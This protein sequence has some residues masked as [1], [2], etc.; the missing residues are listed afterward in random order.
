MD[1]HDNIINLGAADHL[2]EA[3]P[4]GLICTVCNLGITL[5]ASKETG[6]DISSMFAVGI[7]KHYNTKK[8][9]IA[10]RKKFN[11]ITRLN[12]NEIKAIWE[13][14][15]SDM[16]WIAGKAMEQLDGGR[17]YFIKHYVKE[18]EINWDESEEP[19]IK[20]WNLKENYYKYCINYE[21]NDNYYQQHSNERFFCKLFC[22]IFLEHPSFCNLTSDEQKLLSTSFNLQL[23]DDYIIVQAQ[24]KNDSVQYKNFKTLLPK[25]WFND[26]CHDGWLSDEVIDFYMYLLQLREEKQPCNN[27]TKKWTYFFKTS[28]ITTIF[29]VDKKKYNYGK[30]DNVSK[31]SKN[32]PGGCLFRLSKNFFPINVNGNHWTLAVVY[33]NEQKIQYYDSNG[34]SGEYYLHVILQYLKEEHYNKKG[35]HMKSPELWNL[36]LLRIHHNN[37]MDMIVVFCMYFCQL[38]IN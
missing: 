6:R 36:I 3:T 35:I 21:N 4:F 5:H 25:G 38:F 11:A 32:V 15:K 28:F 17:K 16:T 9:A 8:H 14:V 29:N 23:P 30:Y 19:R 2:V 12:Q 7:K 33:M 13:I 24:A 34:G 10:A 22:D 27:G 31:W 18:D 37:K 1:S 26:E 20:G